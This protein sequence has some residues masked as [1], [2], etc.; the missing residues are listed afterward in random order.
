MRQTFAH[1]NTVSSLHLT[2]REKRDLSGIWKI[3]KSSMCIRI[4]I[5]SGSEY[6]INGVEGGSSKGQIDEQ[7]N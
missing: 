1:E 6:L 7:I 3:S 4:E 2:R 5:I